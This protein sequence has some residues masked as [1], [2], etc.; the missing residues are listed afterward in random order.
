MRGPWSCEGS[1]LHCSGMSGPGNGS[2][3]VGEQVVGGAYRG[4]GFLEGKPGKEII[5]EKQIKK[6]SNQTNVKNENERIEREK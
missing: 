5:F 2:G 3:L 1:M 6:K 4:M